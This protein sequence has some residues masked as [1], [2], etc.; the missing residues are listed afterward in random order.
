MG[1]ITPQIT[2]WQARISQ[3]GDVHAFRNL[4]EYFSTPLHAYAYT[5][6]QRKELAEEIVSDIFVKIWRRHQ[7]LDQISNIQGYLFRAVKHQAISYLRT[8]QNRF[9]AIPLAE[10]PENADSPEA[11][12]LFDELQ[13]VMDQAIEGL[14][15]TCRRSFQLV[16]EEGLSY[17]EAASQ[18]NISENT[19]KTHL[20]RAIKKLRKSWLG[21]Q[22]V[23]S[24]NS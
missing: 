19:L 21:Y 16:R 6:V 14:P 1:T 9:S 8:E 23:D 17:R 5:L 20:R 15:T 12:L 3:Q 2:E 4:V 10:Q 18:L 22:A 24:L 11:G 13:T 7:E